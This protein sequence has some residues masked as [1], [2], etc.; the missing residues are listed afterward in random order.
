LNIVFTALSLPFD[1]LTKCEICGLRSVGQAGG[2]AGD[3]G[4]P[5]GGKVAYSVEC[6]L[7]GYTLARKA[8]TLDN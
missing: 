2:Q 4:L 3:Q 1:S 7:T 8:A 5:W 6:V